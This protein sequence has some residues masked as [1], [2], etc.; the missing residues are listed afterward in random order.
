MGKRDP[1]T[2]NDHPESRFIYFITMINLKCKFCDHEL[3]GT[4][5]NLRH[6]VRTNHKNEYKAIIKRIEL[7][8]GGKPPSDTEGSREKREI[9]FSALSLQERRRIG[10][11]DDADD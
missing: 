10:L 7:E 9:P 6:H 5:K 11:D 3:L 2:G 4:W 8:T 1:E